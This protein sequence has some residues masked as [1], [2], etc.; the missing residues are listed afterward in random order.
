[1]HVQC[2]WTVTSVRSCFQ[3][4]R[5]SRLAR[6]RR[7][8]CWMRSSP[9]G[10]SLGADAAPPARPHGRTAARQ[11]RRQRGRAPNKAWQVGSLY[12]YPSGVRTT[13]AGSRGG[14]GKRMD[15]QPYMDK[16][17]LFPGFV[18]L[19]P[20]REPDAAPTAAQRHQAVQ[21]RQVRQGLVCFSLVHFL[22]CL[23]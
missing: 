2:A 13:G 20:G 19:T 10:A 12:K 9:S 5:K 8:R 17:L 15:L 18:A 6:R 16:A 3:V 22:D 11:R 14:R 21:G 4:D 23:V 1:M 7:T